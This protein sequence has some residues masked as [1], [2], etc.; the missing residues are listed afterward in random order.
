MGRA[1][2]ERH[3][4]RCKQPTGCPMPQ[5]NDMSRS[6]AA[7]GENDRLIAVIEMSQSSWLVAG[8]CSSGREGDPVPPNTLAELRRERAGCACS[9]TRS[10]R[11]RPRA[12]NGWNSD[13]IAATIRWSDCWRGVWGSWHRDCRPPTRRSHAACATAGDGALWRSDR[14]AGRE[15]GAPAGERTGQACP[16]QR[17]RGRQCTGAARHD[18]V[19]LALA[20][21][22]LCTR[23]T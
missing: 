3:H 19:G 5:S 16:W 17:T 15:R 12:C 9:P 8:H 10:G 11:S 23:S 7:L 18:P 2:R 21:G 13:P 14:L 4:R 6:L 1:A 22:A 20:A